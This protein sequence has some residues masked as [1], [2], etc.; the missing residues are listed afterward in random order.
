MV[1]KLIIL[2]FVLVGGSLGYNLFPELVSNWDVIP[3]WLVHPITGMVLGAGMFYMLSFQAIKPLEKGAARI[4]KAFGEVSIAYLMFGSIGAIIGLI[5]AVLIS[6]FLNALNMIF[7]SDVIPLV[8]AV[9]FAYFGFQL[10]TSRREEIRRLFSPKTVKAE[11]EDVLERREGES[12]RKY[13][14]L[15]TSAI[16]DGRI[17]DVVKTGFLEGVLVVSQY[18]LQELQHIADSSDSLKRVRGRRGLD[19]LNA[20]QKEEGILL[21][22]DDSELPESDEVDMKLVYLAKKLDGM[23]VTNDF[24]LN[25]VAEFQN[26]PVLNINQLA[27][28]V[29][30]VVIPGE[31]MR[32]M[33]V[34]NGT[35]RAQGVAYLDDG[36]MVVVEEGKHH[37]NERV[38]VVVTSSLQTNAGRMIFAKL[39]NDQKAIDDRKDKK[40]YG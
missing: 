11:N 21:Q 12:Y 18:V 15:D 35:E 40:K 39:V 10:G 33:I 19:I 17:L 3:G 5:L 28:A 26:V 36:T 31:D 2:T 6:I 37:M 1:S 4:E 32:V 16:I 27:N 30:P 14:V 9:G 7:I 38:E 20:L 22:I 24:N 29:K 23:V 34:K 13:K 8:L 25:K